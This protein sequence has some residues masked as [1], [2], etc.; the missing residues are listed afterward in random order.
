MVK[1]VP[2]EDRVM[3]MDVNT[4]IDINSKNDTWLVVQAFNKEPSM[5]MTNPI[6]LDL[7]P[8][9]ACGDQLNGAS[10]SKCLAGIQ[11]GMPCR[12]RLC[13]TSH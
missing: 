4:T 6:F 5:A 9:A 2:T 3:A 7:P 1:K 13:K 11:R 10:R 12:F 8:H